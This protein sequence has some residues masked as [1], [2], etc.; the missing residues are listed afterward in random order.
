MVPH[1]NS[2]PLTRETNK[3]NKNCHI[4]SWSVSWQGWHQQC[5]PY[6]DTTLCISKIDPIL[7]WPLY[8]NTFC[9]TQSSNV[10]VF[11]IHYRRTST[12]TLHTYNTPQTHKHTNTQTHKHTNTQTHKHTNTQTH[13]HTNTQTHKH[14]NTQ[15]HTDTQT[16]RHTHTHTLH[17]WSVA[18]IF[19]L[20]D[21][22]PFQ[23]PNWCY[24]SFKLQFDVFDNKVVIAAK[25]RSSSKTYIL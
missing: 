13:K 8:S 14:T 22:E 7:K 23:Q 10:I 5:D 15:T 17:F 12:S 25:I 20:G 24:S 19:Q 18:S 2:F 6:E 3:V 1:K 9:I 16:H 11:H 4:W 21:I